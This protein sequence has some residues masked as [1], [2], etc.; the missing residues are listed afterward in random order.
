VNERDISEETAL[1]IACRGEQLPMVAWLEKGTNVD[2]VS[3]AVPLPH[4]ILHE[5]FKIYIPSR[6]KILIMEISPVRDF[7]ASS[8]SSFIPLEWLF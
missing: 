7:V 2:L 4:E 8:G 1:L 6:F 3:G 5:K